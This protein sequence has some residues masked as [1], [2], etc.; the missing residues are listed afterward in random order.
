MSDPEIR[1][2]VMSAIKQ[3]L[4]KDAEKSG[5]VLYNGWSTLRLSHGLYIMGFNPGGNPDT[6]KKSIIETLEEIRED[7]CSY[8]DECW[9]KSCRE[10]CRDANHCG[11]SRHQT[12]VT[13][14]AKI[15]GCNIRDVFAANAIFIRSNNQDSLAEKLSLFENCWPIHQMFLSIVQPRTILCLGNGEGSSAFSLLRQKLSSGEKQEGPVKEFIAK[16]HCLI[17]AL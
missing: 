8:K 16:Y 5:A 14:L 15:L 9:H 7:Y 3:H 17:E 6:I 4:G 11:K 13:E 10:D 12:R 1:N 2:M